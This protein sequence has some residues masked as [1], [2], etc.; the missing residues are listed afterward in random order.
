[1]TRTGGQI[2]IDALKANGVT[3]IFGV[4]GESYLAALDAINDAG[5]SLRYYTARQEGGAA[6]MAAAY[7]DATGSPGICFVTRGPGVTNASIAVHTAQQGSTPL[8]LLIGQIPSGHRDREAFQEIDYRRFLGHIT[9]WVAEIDDPARIP[10]YVNRAFKVATSGRPGPV[11]L[12]LPEDMLFGTSDVR[13]LP[14]VKA[15]PAIPSQ[16]DIAAVGD[17]LAT[18][19]RPLLLLGGT[20]WTEEGH[21]AA[22]AFAETH[23]LPVAVGFRRQGLFP[24]DHPNFVGNLG[25]GGN[26]APNDYAKSADMVVALG[27]RLNDGSTLKFSLIKA[28]VPDCT[29]VHIHPG[30]EELGRLYQA[31]LPILADPNEAAKA[32]ARLPAGKKHGAARAEARAAWQAMRTLPPQSGPLDMAEV[33]RALN[34]RLPRDTTMATGAGNAADWPNIH[35]D[36]RQFLG[37]LAP[38]SGAMGMGVPAA[39]AAK[40]ARPRAPAVYIGGDGDF[41]M[42]GQELATA[43]QYDLDPVFIIIDNQMYGTIRDNQERRYP[44]RVSGT[45]LQNPDFATV[46]RG[47][48]AHGER[49]ETTVEFAPALERALSSGKASVIHLIV[50]PDHLGPNMT[51]SSLGA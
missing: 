44:G 22:K 13:D 37:A 11:A 42:N 6:F 7:S 38:I 39:I 47:Y 27:A 36:Y 5:N 18:A 21:Q 4:P 40:V 17:L 31:D 29:L 24:H 9:K 15:T 34:A 23:D 30:A 12:A 8:I 10:E 35:Y 45:R 50:G 46:A 32:L 14:P 2:L 51:L 41:M 3:E 28:P 48:G 19:E 49:V 25:F 43:V 26:P 16:A 20:C 33:M 1:V